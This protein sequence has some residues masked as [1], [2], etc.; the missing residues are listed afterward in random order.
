MD[1]GM[2]VTYLV[3]PLPSYRTLLFAGDGENFKV[4]GRK[5]G[6]GDIGPEEPAP[7]PGDGRGAQDSAFPSAA[8]TRI[9][10][11]PLR[12]QSPRPSRESETWRRCR[13]W[14]TWARLLG[15]LRVSLGVYAA[16]RARAVASRLRSQLADV[17]YLPRRG[18]G[19]CSRRSTFEVLGR[20]TLEDF[21]TDALE[22]WEEAERRRGADAVA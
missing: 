17:A 18:I 6:P 2:P 3:V 5:A 13:A 21:D 20:G 11:E 19:V 12:N 16:E 4:Y 14:A 9:V 10:G 7:R 22:H 15:N 8:T 1:P